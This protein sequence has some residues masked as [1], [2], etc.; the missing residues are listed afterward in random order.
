MLSDV[1]TA[2]PFMCPDMPSIED[3]FDLKLKSE[4]TYN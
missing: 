2:H 1:S 3:W 4:C